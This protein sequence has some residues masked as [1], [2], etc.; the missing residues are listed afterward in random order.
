MGRFNLDD[1]QTVDDRLHE[2]WT[3]FPDAR[4]LTQLV[5]SDDDRFVVKALVYTDSQD[6]RP[7]ATGFAEEKIGSSP[8]NK[9]SA[10]ENAETSAIGRALANMGLSPK[11]QRPTREEMDKV[12]RSDSEPAAPSA[13]PAPTDAIDIVKLAESRY[14][15]LVKAAKDGGLTQA[16]F[17]TTLKAHGITAKM[18]VVDPDDPEN[19]GKFLSTRDALIASGH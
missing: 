8:V 1:Y 14:S 17:K 9:T 5:S 19:D 4:V 7:R 12:A 3:R 6:E 2:F 15:E 18:D 16:V 13:P 10:L 11:G